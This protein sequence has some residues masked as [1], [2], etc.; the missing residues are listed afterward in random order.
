MRFNFKWALAA[1]GFAVGLLVLPLLPLQA[2]G[3]GGAFL[4]T[5][6]YAVTGFWNM[7]GG[8]MIGPFL[9]LN[10]QNPNANSDRYKLYRVDGLADAT[11]T[12]ISTV[13]VPNGNHAGVIPVVLL[14]GIGAGGAVGDWE[15]SGTAYGQ[16]VVERFAGAATVA[17]ATSLSNTG[18]ACSSGATTIT[19]AY[20]VTSISGANTATQTFN[21]QVTVT[22]G[23]GSSAN[24]H[25]LM[26]VDAINANAS[27]ITIS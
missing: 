2:Q 3:Q 4:P 23:G 11:A 27:G 21:I 24:H 15:C 8:V 26:Q 19:T 5:A 18:S 22:K 14:T 1:V 13:T 16:I 7:T 12:T 17:T 9:D 10:A 6:S 25:V 20:S